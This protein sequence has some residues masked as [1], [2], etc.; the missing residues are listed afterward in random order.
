[1]PPDKAYPWRAKQRTLLG[2]G[3]GLRLR[4]NDQLN[5]GGKQ[6]AFLVKYIRDDRRVVTSTRQML[7]VP[8]RGGVPV[9]SQAEQIMAAQDMPSQ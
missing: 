9:N 6:V 8:V 7:K 5:L 2:W 4:W 3:Y 1:L